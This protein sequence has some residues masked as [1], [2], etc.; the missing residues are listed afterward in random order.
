M[1]FS[2]PHCSQHIAIDD[3]ELAGLTADVDF[4]C[5]A[6]GKIIVLH[7]ESADSPPP[8]PSAAV[9]AHRGLN[10]NLLILGALSILLLGGIGVFLAAGISGDTHNTKQDVTNEFIH[11]KF[12]QD[13]IA[14]GA[15]T[16]KD[17][18]AVI[19]ISPAGDGFV[20]VSRE[21]FTW[22]AAREL[23]MNVGA[24]IL[25]ARDEVGPEKLTGMYPDAS[26]ETMWI[27]GESGPGMIDIPD[28]L[29]VT[30]L[31]RPRRAFFRWR[32]ENTYPKNRNWF[33]LEST[34]PQLPHTFDADKFERL[35]VVIQYNNIGP[36]TLRMAAMPYFS[37]KV[38]E[39]YGNDGLHPVPAGRGEV[40]CEILLT[41]AGE[42]DE[43]Q[44]N[45][46]EAEGPTKTSDIIVTTR[47]PLRAVWKSSQDL[48]LI[49]VK[50]PAALARQNEITIPAKAGQRFTV[51][52]TAR[53]N[54]PRPTKL[55]SNLLLKDANILPPEFLAELQA[56]HAGTWHFDTESRPGYESVSGK[57]TISYDL[58]GYAPRDAGTYNFALNLGLFDKR[59]W[60]TQVLKL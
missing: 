47:I 36:T 29:A 20:G 22:E 39:G 25:P 24:E 17:L 28:V 40:Q 37:G 51:G 11:N 30:S 32:S 31:E 46:W 27:R 49:L 60:A 34:E 21:K 52:L 1:E 54:T 57:G 50:A 10:Q 55:A 23:A 33:R 3:D 58:T 56:D 19:G 45:T 53:Y 6:C 26:G 35:H 12:F 4:S 18:E 41:R 5:P 38:A 48:E 44:L 42:I 59:T 16:R 9:R 8:G 14:S 43:V 13:L 15:T 7:P 2:C